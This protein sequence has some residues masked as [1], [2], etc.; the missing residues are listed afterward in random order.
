MQVQ[1]SY[2]PSLSSIVMTALAGFSMAAGSTD[3]RVTLIVSEFSRMVSSSM[4]IVTTCDDVVA[5]N[6]TSLLVKL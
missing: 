1:L 6:V 5:L 4:A 2:L 3:V